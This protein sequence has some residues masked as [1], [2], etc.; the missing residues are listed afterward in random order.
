MQLNLKT[1]LNLKENYP[2]F[3][4]TDIRL[5]KKAS[6]QRIEVT[7][8]SRKGSKGIC[9]ACG[10]KCPGY[11]H[12]PIREFIHVPMWGL[13]VIFQYCMRRLQCATCGVVVETVPWSTGK[14]PLTTSYAWFLSEWVKLI[15]MEEVA[16]QFK[17]T[18]HHVFTSMAMAVA[19]GRERIDL[20]NI[21]AIGVDEIHWS[22]KLGFLTVVY[23]IDNHCK[24]LLWCGE[25]RKTKTIAAFFDW[26]GDE[27]TLALKFVCSDM[28]R[29][30]LK[31]IALRAT[32]ALNILDR[33]HIAKKLGEAIDKVRALETK[34]LIVK[35]KDVILKNSRWCFLKNPKNLTPKQQV[36]L[37]DLLRCNLKTIGAYLLKEHFQRFWEY[38]SPIWARAN[39]L[40]IISV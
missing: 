30:Y 12:L 40:F 18:W 20:T 8:E 22:T 32:N 29:P 35:G 2:L 28:W 6:K 39:S 27:R 15:S 13:A 7:V 5:V 37:K 34:A 23:Q 1:V 24:R 9:S 10:K 3:V 31:M 17:S 19:W 14:S 21:T 4:F 16:R 25:D 11:D 38:T 33:F 26:F 36:K